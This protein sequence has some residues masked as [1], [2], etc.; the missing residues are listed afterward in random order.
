MDILGWFRGLT[1]GEPDKTDS[2][3]GKGLG[4]AWV[5]RLPESNR[6]CLNENTWYDWTG[7][8][9]TEIHLR[10]PSYSLDPFWFE[11]REVK[12]EGV[13]KIKVNHMQEQSIEPL[14]VMVLPVIGPQKVP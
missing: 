12:W 14:R 3:P 4:Y 1:K 13:R 11:L 9:V 10:K 8:D 6:I 2:I 7:R 5:K